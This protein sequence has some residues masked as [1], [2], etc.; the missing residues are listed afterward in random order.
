M[1]HVTTKVT[2]QNEVHG[3]PGVFVFFELF[4]AFVVDF[5]SFI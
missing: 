3:N 5:P 4:V 2:K 1:Q